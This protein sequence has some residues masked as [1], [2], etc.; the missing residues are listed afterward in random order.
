MNPRQRLWWKS[1]ARAANAS[2]VAATTSP[3]TEETIT[4][5]VAETKK[6]VANETPVT[7]TKKVT[8]TG[9]TSKTSKKTNKTRK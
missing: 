8:K 4:N 3:S 1:R 9:T 6:A 5:I 2:V 7:T